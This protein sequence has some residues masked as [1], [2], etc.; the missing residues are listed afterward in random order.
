[1]KRLIFVLII[2]IPI[3]GYSQTSIGLNAGFVV[4]TNSYE[5]K[6]TPSSS[7]KIGVDFKARMYKQIGIMSGIGLYT[8]TCA[9]TYQLTDNYGNK[10]VTNT[11][12]YSSNYMAIPI[13][14]KYSIFDNTK[15]VPFVDA[16]F[17]AM[18]KISDTKTTILKANKNVYYSSIGT[19]ANI[20]V[21]NRFALALC[22][23]YLI[24]L[25]SVYDYGFEKIKY[26][27]VNFAFSVS[28]NITNKK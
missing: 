7:S 20:N 25:T 3:F 14:L 23:N 12:Y 17:I 4:P 22:A 16:S 19:G 8:F 24:P 28:Y 10:S 21:S 1:M 15:V 27:G 18:L 26:E 6:P 11:E 2:A 9:K 5:N 13:G